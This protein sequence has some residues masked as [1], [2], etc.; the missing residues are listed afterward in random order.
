[1]R[2]FFF[3]TGILLENEERKFQCFHLEGKFLISG[4]LGGCLEVIIPPREVGKK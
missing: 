1:V 3:L 4:H 2:T